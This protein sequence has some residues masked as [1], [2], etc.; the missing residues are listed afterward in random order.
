MGVK[1]LCVDDDAEMLAAYRVFQPSQQ[2]PGQA[3][4]TLDTVQA[5]LEALQA[6]T[7]SGPYA[8]IIS[9]FQMPGM[10]GIQFLRQAQQLAPDSVRIM[11]TGFADL[12]V[13]VDA[14]NEAFIFRFLTKPC[15]QRLFVKTIEAGIKQYRLITAEKELLEKTLAGAVK[16]LTE[17]LALVNP[18]AFGRA[19]RV[20]RLVQQLE[21][22]L[23]VESTW[24]LEVAALLCQIGCVTVPEDI[25]RKLHLGAK[26]TKEEADIVA[27]HPQVGHDLIAHIP[28]LEAI[29]AII[30]HQEN[31]FDGSGRPPHHSV[32][33]E[34]PLG[35][36]ILKVALDFD[37]LASKH[38]SK[39]EALERLKTRTGWY[40]PAII[41]ALNSVLT[42]EVPWEMQE[43]TLCHLLAMMDE[44][45]TGTT[46][47]EIR[48]NNVISDLRGMI[49]AEDVLTENDSLLLS[50]G[51]ELTPQLL[52]KLR[53]YSRQGLIQE[54]IRVLVPPG[55]FS[56]A[57]LASRR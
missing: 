32:G 1:V 56:Q 37:S 28:R 51:H 31:R 52:D 38:L 30:A 44:A 48:V 6:V 39:V 8:V 4:F 34:I 54:P 12:N 15:S 9:D 36:R 2:N 27:N 26:L 49:L 3:A 43:V 55:V 17:V 42:K 7:A 50:K 19:S 35:A 20:Q 46:R 33:A 47:G 41:D 5:P 13:A 25:L 40:D 16:A 53:H 11:L 29:A 18:T 23:E 57:S 22:E 24:Q 10:N 21:A 14:L 45:Q